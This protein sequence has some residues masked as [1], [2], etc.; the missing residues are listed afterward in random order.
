[1]GIPKHLTSLQR[2]LYQIKMQLLEPDMEL[3]TGSKLG[4]KY[5]KAVYCHSVYLTYMQSEMPGWMNHQLETRWAGEIS[6][7]SDMQMIPL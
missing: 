6:A 1:M 4:K 3:Q 7:V 2:Y 5:I